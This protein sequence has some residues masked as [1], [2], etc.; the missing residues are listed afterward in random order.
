MFIALKDAEEHAAEDG[1]GI[2]ASG[3]ELIAEVVSPGKDGIDR[4]RDR[5]RRAYAGREGLAG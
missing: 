5:K 1:L 4:D 3:V 2:D